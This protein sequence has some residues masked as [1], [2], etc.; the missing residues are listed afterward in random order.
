MEGRGA[1]LRHQLVVLR[2]QPRARPKPSWADRALIAAP[3]GVIPR[4]RR[5]SRGMM[6]TPDT[7]LRWHRD[8]VRR[9]WAAKSRRKR[10]G[11]PAIHRNICGLVLR[12][13]HE[14][15][16]W[17]CRRIT[18]SWPALASASL[19]R[20]C[21]ETMRRQGST[22]RRAGPARRGAVPALPGSSRRG[23]GVLTV[24]LLDGTTVYV[25][26]VIEHAS[27]RIRILGVTRTRP[28]CG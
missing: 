8:I 15:P 26:A 10:P 17:G 27:R 16:G 3:L 19:Q 24:D 11:R 21:G 9:R 13:A 14:N 12:L 25:L 1:P 22:R 4:T 28:A 6:V 2:R 7:V 23:R 5:A 20:P 18:V